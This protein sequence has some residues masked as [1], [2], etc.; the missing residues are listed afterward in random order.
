LNEKPN[1]TRRVVTDY[2]A[3]TPPGS[4][5]HEDDG[6]DE[7]SPERPLLTEGSRFGAYSVG[8]LIGEGGMARIYRAEHEGLRRQVALKV[9]LDEVD[10]D[11][12]EHARFLREARIAAA[13]KHTNVVNIFDVGVHRGRPYLVM[14]LLEGMDLEAYVASKGA[15]DEPT[16]MDLII[17]IAAALAA[18]HQAGIVHRDL[19]PGNIFLARGR[20]KEIEPKLLDFG[21][22]KSLA[23]DQLR[24]TSTGDLPMGTPFYMSPEA[25]SGLDVTAL[26]DQYALGVVLY[27]CATGVNPFA[28]ASTFG[29]VVRQARTGDYPR[30]ASLNPRLSGRMVSIIECA[31]NPDPARRFSSMRAMGRELLQL[32]GQRTRITW[33]LGF[34]EDSD[35]GQLA[36]VEAKSPGAERSRKG[37]GRASRRKSYLLPLVLLVGLGTGV[38]WSLWPRAEL[39]S[40]SVVVS[41]VKPESDGHDSALPKAEPIVFEES[42][43]TPPV[44]PEREVTSTTKAKRGERS[45]A[46]SSR[47]TARRV[48]AARPRG[49]TERVATTPAPKALDADADWAVSSARLSSRANHGSDRGTN[50][51]PI[52]E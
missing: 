31:M 42:T 7:A 51:A 19:K 47:R 13:I 40:D 39:Q 23:Q 12:D 29:E 22:S 25:T 18:V 33:G 35:G 9:L 37:Q 14:E 34:N 48:R 8:P 36:R 2:R 38:G 49:V 27:E 3:L 16:L 5:P 20:N 43:A 52:L 15:L 11:S 28:D 6:L 45:A 1:P 26:S 17:P 46:G 4:S 24:L 21:I 32:A 50:N 10:P 44:V 30:V 41:S